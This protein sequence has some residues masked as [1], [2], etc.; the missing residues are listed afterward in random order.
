MTQQKDSQVQTGSMGRVEASPNRL[1]ITSGGPILGRKYPVENQLRS[2]AS[3]SFSLQVHPR[4]TVSPAPLSAL[5]P[6]VLLIL[7]IVSCSP[8]ALSTI[9]RSALALDLFER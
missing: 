8:H 7:L 9:R 5:K 6:A 1:I 4:I 2:T 3:L